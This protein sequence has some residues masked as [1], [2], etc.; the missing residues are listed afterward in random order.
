MIGRTGTADLDTAMTHNVRIVPFQLIIRVENGIE[1]IRQNETYKNSRIMQH[2]VTSTC[3][4]AQSTLACLSPVP[5]R[6][7]HS[8]A[9]I[10]TSCSC[11]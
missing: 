6:I 10:A 9:F 1:L 2:H 4:A 11:V 5:L 3:D 8:H 7:C